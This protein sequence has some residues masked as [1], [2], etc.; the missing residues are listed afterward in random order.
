MVIRY[1]KLINKTWCPLIIHDT[2]ICLKGTVPLITSVQIYSIFLLEYNFSTILV[3]YVNAYLRASSWLFQILSYSYVGSRHNRAHTVSVVTR[4]ATGLHVSR[5]KSEIWNTIKLVMGWWKVMDGWQMMPWFEALLYWV[6]LISFD[7]GHTPRTYGRGVFINGNYNHTE[8]DRSQF[9]NWLK[10]MRDQMSTCCVVLAMDISSVLEQLLYGGTSDQKSLLF[11]W[12]ASAMVTFGTELRDDCLG[13]YL[14]NIGMSWNW[15]YNL[16]VCSNH[17]VTG[18]LPLTY[19]VCVCVC[20]NTELS[21]SS[22]IL[23]SNF[24]IKFF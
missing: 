13:K 14:T 5:S 24:V 23:Y 16:E 19:S 22:S 4:A 3:T 7:A 12:L 6:E 18:V 1:Q 20:I 21:W 17:C 2:E 11:S 9:S 10:N 8:T 15:T